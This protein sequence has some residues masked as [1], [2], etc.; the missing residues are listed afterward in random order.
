MKLV[1]K[2]NSMV[3]G[4]GIFLGGWEDS[5]TNLELRGTSMYFGDGNGSKCGLGFYLLVCI[6]ECISYINVILYSLFLLAEMG[7]TT[8]FCWYFCDAVQVVDDIPTWLSWK[9]W[10]KKEMLKFK[11]VFSAKNER[12]APIAGLCQCIVVP[13]CRTQRIRIS[14]NYRW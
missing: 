4:T 13:S 5:E 9:S 3:Y 8:I 6:V 14:K 10:I 11:V 7:K 1:S 12:H 2:V